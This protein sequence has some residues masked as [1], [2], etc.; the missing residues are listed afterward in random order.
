M[1]GI[2]NHKSLVGG[3]GVCCRGMFE[4][5]SIY[6]DFRILKMVNHVILVMTSQHRTG[7]KGGVV[8]ANLRHDLPHAPPDEAHGRRIVF[9]SEPQGVGSDLRWGFVYYVR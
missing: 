2:P 8:T 5:S 9:T 3:S 1:E 6:R 4:N 7:G